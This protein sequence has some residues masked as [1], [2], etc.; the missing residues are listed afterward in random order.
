LGKILL[1]I[2]DILRKLKKLK[3]RK[4]SLEPLLRIYEENLKAEER[5]RQEGENI[6]S[7]YVKYIYIHEPCEYYLDPKPQPPER[8]LQFYTEIEWR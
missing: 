7:K 2:L 6:R 4:Y 1:K 3:K 8:K 5:E